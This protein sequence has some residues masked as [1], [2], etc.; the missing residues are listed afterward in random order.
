M[1]KSR[2]GSYP[3]DIG[4][5]SLFSDDPDVEILGNV[6]TESRDD[7]NEHNDA[8]RT[9][10]PRTLEPLSASDGAEVEPGEPTPAVDVRG[11]G[12]DG[13]PALRFDGG[14]EDGLPTGVGDRP[15][16]MGIPPGRGGS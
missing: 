11:T 6:E 13:E 9:P 15:E 7:R 4:Q 2:F 12:V 1:A 8:T 16:G 3:A 10:D 5:L 14:S